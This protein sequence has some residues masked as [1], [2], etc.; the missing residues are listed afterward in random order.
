VFP[1]GLILALKL[2]TEKRASAMN[3]S[4]GSLLLL[5]I[6]F[7]FTVPLYSKFPIIWVSNIWNSHPT[8]KNFKEF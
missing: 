6:T 1:K 8:C 5:F 4:S 3:T 7:L 2:G